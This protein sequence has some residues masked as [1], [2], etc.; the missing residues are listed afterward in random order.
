MQ[1]ITTNTGRLTDQQKLRVNNLLLKHSSVFDQDLTNGYNQYSGPHYCKL[2]FA[3]AERPS[4]K[5]ATCVQ[6][7]SQ[8][9]TLLQRVCDELTD[10]NVLG[11][12]QHNPPPGT[13]YINPISDLHV[14]LL[15]ISI[16]IDNQNSKIIICIKLK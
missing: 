16:R 13:T 7:N 12:P 6:Y 9:N 8:M 15:F 4:S 3:T 1:D 14:L 10:S 2:Q 5:K 11:V